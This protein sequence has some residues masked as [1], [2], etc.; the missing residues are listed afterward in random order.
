MMS[1]DTDFSSFVSF[2]G[3]S[4]L[5]CSSWS[6][7]LKK[8]ARVY[9]ITKRKIT[10][11]RLANQTII[12]ILCTEYIIKFFMR[13]KDT[14]LCYKNYL[15]FCS[16]LKKFQLFLKYTCTIL[17]KML[18][19]VSERNDIET[20]TFCSIITLVSMHYTKKSSSSV[21]KFDLR[22]SSQ[23]KGLYHIGT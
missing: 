11:K 10:L 17:P 12:D 15:L 22:S 5:F 19:K 2:F 6:F 1:V 4:Y 18:F 8:K 9:S 7:Y 14:L 23:V 13:Q 21:K 3:A 20:I 16:E